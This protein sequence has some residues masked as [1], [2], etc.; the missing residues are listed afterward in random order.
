VV[1]DTEGLVPLSELDVPEFD[2]PVPDVS[3]DVP[4]VA[5]RLAWVSAHATAATTAEPTTLA[6]VI[7][8]VSAAVRR[9]PFSR[10]DIA[11]RLRR[12]VPDGSVPTLRGAVVCGLCA[13]QRPGVCCRSGVDSLAHPAS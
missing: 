10:R 3:D 13:A 2:V 5:A 6:A 4:D 8:M 12:W 11:A 1:F 7:P 9:R